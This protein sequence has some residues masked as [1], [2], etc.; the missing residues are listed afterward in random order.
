MTKTLGITIF[1]TGKIDQTLEI[2][3]P[4]L[5]EEEII[6][7]LT[8]GDFLTTIGHGDVDSAFVY[9]LV[10]DRNIAKVIYQSAGDDLE[11]D[12]DDSDK[13][14]EFSHLRDLFEDQPDQDS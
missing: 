8:N 9:D 3:D 1:V 2:L 4:S 7:G 13:D 11:I 12:F 10:K 6:K 14:D 5:S